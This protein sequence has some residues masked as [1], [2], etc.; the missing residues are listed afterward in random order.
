[1]VRTHTH[2]AW[3]QLCQNGRETDRWQGQ[4]ARGA[5]GG[6]IPG[7]GTKPAPRAGGRRGLTLR[8]W[9]GDNG[10]GLLEKRIAGRTQGWRRGEASAGE[11][12]DGPEG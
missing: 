11:A 5:A 7:S 12:W 4:G 8:P 3:V 9:T 6:S 2:V 1:M 10:N